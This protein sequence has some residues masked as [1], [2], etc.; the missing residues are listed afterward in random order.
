MAIAL[1]SVG[2]VQTIP[3]NGSN[4]TL[5]VTTNAADCIVVEV[6]LAGADANILSFSG[7]GAVWAS[8]IGTG[9]GPAS[10]IYVG[11][12]CTAG[13][14]TI[15]LNGTVAN[16]T[17]ESLVVSVWSGVQTSPS[18]IDHTY[19]SGL[20]VNGTATTVG[21]I[22]CTNGDL[23][24]ANLAVFAPSSYTGTPS[25][26]AGYAN[27]SLVNNVTAATR[28]LYSSYTTATS[29]STTSYTTVGNSANDAYAVAMVA[30]TPAGLPQGNHAI[31]YTYAAVQ[32]AAT[33]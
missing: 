5:P 22:S 14:T 26:S 13:A 28:D 4:I 16:G 6:S 3:A 8:R 32:R 29:T 24:I 27:T 1:R 33:R 17:A 20:S 9:T 31:L 18:P 19:T 30:L 25:W 21:P 7:A 12:G 11:Y 2:S 23:I 10:E 15:V